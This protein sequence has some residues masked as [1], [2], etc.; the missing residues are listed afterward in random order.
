MYS[1]N[2]VCFFY[3]KGGVEERLAINDN[4]AKY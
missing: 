4:E 2:F 1:M 3:K